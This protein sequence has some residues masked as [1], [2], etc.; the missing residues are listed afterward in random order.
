MQRGYRMLLRL[1]P[2]DYRL[3]FGEEMLAVFTRQ[4]AERRALGWLNYARFLLHETFGLL[5]SAARERPPW[6]HFVPAIGGVSV[7]ALL[8]LVIYAVIFKLFDAV[9]RAIGHISFSTQEPISPVIAMTLCVAT[10]VGLLPLFF[11]LNMR[12]LQRRR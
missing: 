10:L 4:A 9:G 5:V 12:L 3:E 6:L 8:H 1:Y 7:A 2:R 11:L